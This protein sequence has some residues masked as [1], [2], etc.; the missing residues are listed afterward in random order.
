MIENGIFRSEFLIREEIELELD[1]LEDERL[2]P[3]I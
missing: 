1:L 2:Y 3:I